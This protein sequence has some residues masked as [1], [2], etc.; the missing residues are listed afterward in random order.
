MWG[1]VTEANRC[2]TLLLVQK[3]GKLYTLTVGSEDNESK[4]AVM[5]FGKLFVED[6]IGNGG[7]DLPRYQCILTW[8]LILQR[9]VR[10][11]YIYPWH[12]CAANLKVVVLCACVCVCVSVCLSTTILALQATT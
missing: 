12:A 9:V 1:T 5:T 11:T 2:C 3:H 4:S 8:G 6:N 7:Q 10:G